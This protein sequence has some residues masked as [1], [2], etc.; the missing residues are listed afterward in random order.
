ME[1]IP[2]A[3]REQGLELTSTGHTTRMCQMLSN[4]FLLAP[5]EMHVG[6]LE[7]LPTVANTVGGLLIGLFLVVLGYNTPAAA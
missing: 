4:A 2:E 1:G 3:V 7:I 5:I 6:N